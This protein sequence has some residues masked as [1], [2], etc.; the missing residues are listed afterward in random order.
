M[1]GWGHRDGQ[2]SIELYG[3]SGKTIS[4]KKETLFHV[5]EG[6]STTVFVYPELVQAHET[7]S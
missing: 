3:W 2:Q 6:E 5:K 1:M 4:Q 7:E